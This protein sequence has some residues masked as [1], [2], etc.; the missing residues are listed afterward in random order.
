MLDVFIKILLKNIALSGTVYRY[1]T[2]R[3]PQIK[4]RKKQEEENKLMYQNKF[5]KK[6]I[7]PVSDDDDFLQFIKLV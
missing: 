4:V 1:Y 3:Q 5:K 7:S 2:M 6:R